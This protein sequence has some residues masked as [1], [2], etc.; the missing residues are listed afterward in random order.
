MLGKFIEIAL[1]KQFT[2]HHLT[3]QELDRTSNFNSLFCV[4]SGIN[5]SAVSRLKFTKMEIAQST[6]DV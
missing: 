2:I 3:C 1:V 4:A 5:H 6:W